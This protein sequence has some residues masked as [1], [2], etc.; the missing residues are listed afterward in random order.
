MKRLR[1][2]LELIEATG[3]LDHRG[4]RL[5]E[6]ELHHRTHVAKMGIYSCAGP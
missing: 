1:A 5:A 2:R 4:Q 6:V 3:V